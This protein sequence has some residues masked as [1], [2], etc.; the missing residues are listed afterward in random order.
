MENFFKIFDSIGNFKCRPIQKRLPRNFVM[1]KLDVKLIINHDA[2][3]NRSIQS[4][5]KINKNNR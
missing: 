3:I 2:K 5:I 1:S 4:K